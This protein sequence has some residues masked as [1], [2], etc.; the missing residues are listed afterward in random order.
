QSGSLIRLL[1]YVV[2]KEGFEKIIRKYFEQYSYKSANTEDFITTVES[3]IPDKNMRDFLETWLLQNRYPIISIEEDIDKNTYILRQE[4]AS[5]FKDTD[6]MSRFGYKWTIPIIYTTSVSRAPTMV[7]FRKDDNFITIPKGNETFIKLNYNYMGIYYTNYTPTLWQNLVDNVEM[8]NELEQVQLALE[9]EKLFEA[10]VID[11]GITLKLISKVSSEPNQYG[12]SPLSILFTLR[13]NL[14]FDQR[15]I[16]LLRRFYFSIRVK[17]KMMRRE[18]E[19]LRNSVKKIKREA[20][21][22]TR[23]LPRVPMRV[24]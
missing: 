19:K 5:N 4:S 15:A 20:P 13:N 8:M 6:N 2:G 12:V 1:D 24:Q 23:T 21:S 22:L 9:A 17:S 14:A 3:V 18:E 7:W 16:S 10:D 11:C